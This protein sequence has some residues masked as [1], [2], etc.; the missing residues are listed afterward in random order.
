MDRRD[1]LARL[2]G[3]EIGTVM[4]NPA[5][6]GD[7]ADNILRA[8]DTYYGEYCAF[9]NTYE[10]RRPDDIQCPECWH[11]FLPQELIDTHNAHGGRRVTT[12]R[13]ISCCPLCVHDF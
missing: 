9:H 13:E 10:P 1:E 8:I 6:M 12:V 4:G 11:R 2:I 3:R 7:A 5:H